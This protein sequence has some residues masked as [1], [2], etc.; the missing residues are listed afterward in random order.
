MSET[1]FVTGATGLAGANVCKQLI[2]RGDAV[3]ALARASADTGLLAALGVDVVAG[4]ITDADDVRKGATGCDSAIHCAVLLGGAGQDLD[5]S[6]AVNTNGTR[7]VLDAVRPS[8]MRRVVAV[9]TGTFFDTS[10][11]LER[12]DAPVIKGTEFGSVHHHQNGRIR[13]RHGPGCSRTGCR[14]HP[15]GRDLRP[16]A[17]GEQ[18]SRARRASIGCSSPALRGRLDRYLKFPVSWVFGDDVARGCILALDRGVSGERYMLDGRPEDVVSIAEAC[19][20]ICELAGIDHRVDDIDPSDDPELAKVFGPTLVAIAEKAKLAGKGSTRRWPTPRPTSG[21]ATTRSAWTMDFGPPP[22]GCVKWARSTGRS[23]VNRRWIP[24]GP[25]PSS[26]SADTGSAGPGPAETGSAEAGPAGPGSVVPP[27][28]AIRDL[29]EVR[30][31]ISRPFTSTGGRTPRS[32]GVTLVALAAGFGQFGFTA[33]LG[34]VA[35][36]FGHVFQGSTITDRAG[37]SGT[38]LGL[39]LAVVR[40]PSLGGLPITAWADR[41]GRRKVLL[42]ACGLGL[43]ITAASALSPTYWLFVIIFALG[44]PFLSAAAAVAQ[45]E[46]AELTDSSQR[47]SAVALVAAGYAVGAAPLPVSTDWPVAR[48]DTGEYSALPSFL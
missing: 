24:V 10:Q 22:N 16:V 17:S 3:R 45:V 4:D 6:G 23:A 8:G 32:I 15:P 14:H 41:A 36:H 47:A 2:E 12:E 5:D 39:G 28:P 37:L 20:R 33:T 43:A 31:A 13:G 48:W 21:S 35:R 11:G 27:P 7:Y 34:D 38:Q 29:T 44:R 30:E 18:R 26:R 19:T 9:S 25:A 1:V 40:L 46:A 42:F